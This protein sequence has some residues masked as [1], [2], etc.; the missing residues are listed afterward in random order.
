VTTNEGLRVVALAE[1]ALK[2]PKSGAHFEAVHALCVVALRVYIGIL[3]LVEAENGVAAQ[4]LLRTL[5]ETVVSAVILAKHPEKLD[6]FAKHGKLTLLRMARSIDKDSA[7]AKKQ[8]TKAMKKAADA[9]C[10]ALIAHFKPTY[11]WHMLRSK[12]AFN[13]AEQPK[14]FH[15]SFYARASAIAHGEPFTVFQH[16]DAEAKT[17]R[18]EARSA[19]WEKWP[20]QAYVMSMFLMLHLIRRVSKTFVLGLEDDL[21]AADKEVGGLADKQMESA[22]ELPDVE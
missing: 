18:I 12:D 9:E 21:S 15:E 2:A 14:N 20:M 7:F 19:E 5:F 3:Q 13:E 6:D 11:N 22:K 16:K 4:A 8:M 10:N 1:K 17:W